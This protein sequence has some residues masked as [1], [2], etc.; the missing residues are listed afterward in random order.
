M[1][2]IALL[3]LLPTMA[4][5]LPADTWLVA[6]GNN[7]GEPGEVGLLYAERDARELAEVMRTAAGVSTR[8]TLLLLGEDAPT[9]RRELLRI[10]TALRQSKAPTA[11]LVFYSGHADAAGLHLGG[12]QLALEELRGLVASSPAGLRLLIVDACRSGNV[13]RVKGVRTGRTFEL[14]LEDRTAAE[15]MAIITSS[16]AG[17]SSQESDRLRASFFSHHLLN[18]LRGAADQDGDG[19][20]T[21]A[22][23]YAYTYRQT[24]RSSG[25]T[26]DL[27]HPTYEY[28][29]RGRRAVVMSRP[30]RAGASNGRLRLGAA[31]VYLVAERREGGP[32]VAEVAPPRDR[33]ALSLPANTYFVQQRLPTEYR[34]YSVSLA[35]AGEVDLERLPFRAVAYDRLV[36]Q[37][38]APQSRVHAFLAMAG[39]RGEQV[40]GEGVTPQ[41]VLGYGLDLHWFSAGLRVRGN[42][43]ESE[44]TDDASTRRHSE[45][46][47]GLTLQR[48]VDL[49]ALSVS[50]GLLAEGVLHRQSFTARESPTRTGYG[51][52]LGGLFSLERH[53][54]AGLALRLEGG[55]VVGVF[56]RGVT[57]GGAQTDTEQ[58]TPLTWWLAAGV[59]WRL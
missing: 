8:R 36:R 48:F 33:A 13:T 22:E 58:A 5:A 46:G 11:L 17:E 47:V 21:L 30:G 41:L 2:R 15:G 43:V 3:L 34:E 4:A 12:S 25:R 20:V 27:Q 49:R 44:G 52:S 45:L 37:R 28:D 19:Q 35:A 14:A 29:V 38:G 50:F 16:A 59:A 7:V 10:N 18:A 53:L 32:V 1:I 24:L 9:V 42:S 55:P 23:A 31:G 39:A 26:L 40:A 57:V 51:A 54:G 6:I 56:E